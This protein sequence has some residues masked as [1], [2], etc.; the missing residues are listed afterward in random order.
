MILWLHTFQYKLNQVNDIK[1]GISNSTHD[2]RV[3]FDVK[4]GFVG[5]GN[6]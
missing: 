4:F 6:D 3:Q 2:D 5:C 1:K